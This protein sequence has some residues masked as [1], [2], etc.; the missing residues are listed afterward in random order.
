[1][2][3]LTNLDNEVIFKKAFTDKLVFQTFV[4]DVLGLNIEIATIETEKRFA[5]KI[6]NVDFRLDIFA[7]SVDKRVVIELQKVEYDHNFDRLLHYFLAMIIE[8]QK[9]SKQYGIDQKVYAIIIMTE[10][11]TIVDRSNKPIRN[12][13]LMMEINPKNLLGDTVD[14]Y[15]HQFVVLNPNHPEENTP[16]RIRDWLD[17]FYQSIHN[18]QRFVLNQNNEGIKRA[19]DI[20]SYD[21]LS[22]EEV[23]EMKNRNAAATKAVIDEFQKNGKIILAMQSESIPI[24]VIA[25]IMEK[26]EEEILSIINNYHP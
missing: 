2:I 13:V 18:P 7:E 9:S 14:L 20:I 24:S 5:P 25:K 1:M 21:N 3:T 23:A 10:P 17:L 19:I 16:Q 11:F 6:G 26:T 22:G 12:E 4:N 8:Q 15:G